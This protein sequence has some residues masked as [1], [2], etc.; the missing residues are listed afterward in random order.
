MGT[1]RYDEGDEL[2]RLLEGSA[3]TRELLPELAVFVDDLL[4][5]PAPS[6][7]AEE[8]HVAAM[9]SESSRLLADKGD[10]V[11]RPVSNAHGPARQ[12]S[13]LPMRR[14]IPMVKLIAKVMAPLVA[15]FTL[16]GGLAYAQV[17]PDPLQNAVAD[18]GGA[19]GLDIPGTDDGDVE[20]A[21]DVDEV[22]NVDEADEA[23]VED[24]AGDVD[25][26][27]ENDEADEND[28]SGPGGGSD[29]EADDDS[30]D[31]GHG[32]GG[33]DDEPETDDDSDNSGHSGS[34]SDDEVDEVESED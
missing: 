23:D 25:E 10:P 7:G 4:V 28:N 34:D 24:E 12:V 18:A 5:M 16:M 11:A 31:S 30:D 29:D 26:T 13:G 27:D 33:S 32:G 3:E 9:M 22:D 19:V 20:E 21:G 1:N 8:L 2:E 15:V 14:S 17:L 6:P